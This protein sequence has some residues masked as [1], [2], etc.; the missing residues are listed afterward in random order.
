LVL[1]KQKRKNMKTA[2]STHLFVVSSLCG[3]VLGIILLILEGVEFLV[4]R[5]GGLA[6]FRFFVATVCLFSVTVALVL[7]CSRRMQRGHRRGEEEFPFHSNTL[8]PGKHKDNVQAVERM[9]RAFYTKLLWKLLNEGHEG[10]WIGMVS[11]TEFNVGTKEDLEARLE[12]EGVPYFLQIISEEPQRIRAKEVFLRKGPSN[13]SYRLNAKV[14]GSRH[15]F[16]LDTGATHVSISRQDFDN[17][18][19]VTRNAPVE[20]ATDEVA[21]K[22]GKAEIELDDGTKFRTEVATFGHLTEPLFGISGIDHCEL[23]IP[24]VVNPLS[25]PLIRYSTR[26]HSGKNNNN[27]NV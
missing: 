4:T 24:A 25:A 10:K 14:N 3:L 23:T 12:K 17:S 16:L 5:P 19:L 22:V 20:T 2:F 11:E 27:N 8:P 13:N 6:D 15:D 26:Q 9:Y 7:Y 21:G 18:V 1:K